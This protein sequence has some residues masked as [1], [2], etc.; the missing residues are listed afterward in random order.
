[1]TKNF[2]RK[3]FIP[4]EKGSYFIP[5]S[6]TQEVGC[7]ANVAL[8]VDGEDTEQIVMD[9]GVGM[10]NNNMGIE[11]SI[12]DFDVIDP[13]ITKGLVITHGHLDHIGSIYH[14]LQ[15]MPH[16]I[17]IYTTPFTASIISS[18]LKERGIHKPNIVIVDMNSEF[19]VGRFKFQMISVTHS[20]PETQMIVFEYPDGTRCLHTADYKIDRNPIVGE[21]TNESLLKEMGRKGINCIVADSTNVHNDCWT[22]SEG[23]VHE[24]LFNLVERLK[25]KRVIVSFF[26]SN[27]AR[28]KGVFEVAARTGRKV[29]ILGRSMNNMFEIA[30]KHEYMAYRHL[31]VGRNNQKTVRDEDLLILCTGSQGEQRSALYKLATTGSYTPIQLTLE[32]KIKTAIIFSAR[33]IPGREPGI[34]DIKGKLFDRGAEI[35]DTDTMKNIHTSGHA[36][37][38]ETEHLVDM[39]NPKAFI[40][41]HG[42]KI[43]IHK[44][45]EVAKKRGLKYLIPYNGCIIKMSDDDYKIVGKLDVRLKGL[46]GEKDLIVDL[47]SKMIE[48]R[49]ALG[50]EGVLHINYRSGLNGWEVLSL[51]AVGLLSNNVVRGDMFRNL[52]RS[53][54]NRERGYNIQ[55]A[56][57]SAILNRYGK[58]PV[59]IA[60][61]VGRMMEHA[62]VK[63]SASAESNDNLVEEI[64]EEIEP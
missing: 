43:L 33:K 42:T 64:K 56:L 30:H 61:D 10:L 17:P 47:S 62:K 31:M 1:M 41:I 60:I 18:R 40:P 20:I 3:Y 39:I 35:Y 26:S 28:K 13:S 7:N 21:Q 36:S 16:G 34:D 27:I 15:K 25:G 8:Y 48:G 9:A 19:T 63:R 24:E 11:Q 46:D 6:G 37:R 14:F 55:E 45:A 5:L 44:A 49:K 12:P 29:L 32:D 38:P 22:E 2:K 57:Q 50:T 52:I 59:V 23:S 58:K 53:V 51:N 4:K 54:I